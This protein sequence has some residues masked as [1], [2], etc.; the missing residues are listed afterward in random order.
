MAS[1]QEIE[2]E[3]SR[4]KIA[5]LVGNKVK[6]LRE[7]NGLSQVDLAGKM[8]GQFDT[9]NI[10]RIESGRANPTLFT[11]FRLAEALEV[12]LSDLVDIQS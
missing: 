8:K 5:I 9:T 4:K 3:Q 6:Q 7:S 12:K 11:L 1:R 2:L 10:S